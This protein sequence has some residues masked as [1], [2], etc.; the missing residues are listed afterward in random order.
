MPFGQ[1]ETTRKRIGKMM[2]KHKQANDIDYKLTKVHYEYENFLEKEDGTKYGF[3]QLVY[4]FDFNRLYVSYQ[5]ERNSE[6]GMVNHGDVINKEDIE[7]ISKIVCNVGFEEKE[8]K[9]FISAIYL[10]M[11]MVD[12]IREG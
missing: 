8:E 2:S 11:K 1:G 7:A 5:K 4:S 9:A 12:K 10:F 6:N 3:A